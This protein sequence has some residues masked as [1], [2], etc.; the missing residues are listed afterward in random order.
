MV[1]FVVD[2]VEIRAITK[3]EFEAVLDAIDTKSPYNQ[4][5]GKRPQRVNMKKGYIKEGI[6]MA[7]LLGLRREEI[8]SLTYK[9][10]KVQTDTGDLIIVTDN[11]KV[12]RITGKKYKKKY[13]PVYP[14]LMELL[15]D[16]GYND[17]K[18][19]DSYILHPERGTLQAKTMMNA[20]SKGFSHYFNQA[21]PDKKPM[22][23]RVLRKTF[24]SFLNKAVGD[25]MIDLSSHSSMDVV[26]KHYLDKELVAKGRDMRMF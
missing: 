12:E 16:M 8:I 3:N 25:D 23:F 2:D 7:L 5:G 20:L 21:F 13:I 1:K 18:D 14:Q 11:L 17:L 9:D 6:R 19:S 24:L 15:I 22:A 4:I 10:V 26:S